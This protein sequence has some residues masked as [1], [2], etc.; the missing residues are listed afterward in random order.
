MTALNKITG[1]P[2]QTL[3][4][5]LDASDFPS[6][7][8]FALDKF[9]R[10]RA[11][12]RDSGQDYDTADQMAMHPDYGPDLNRLARGVKRLSHAGVARIACKHSGVCKVYMRQRGDVFRSL[13]GLFYWDDGKGETRR[14]VLL[15]AWRKGAQP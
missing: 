12:L 7:L 3:R 2:F 9:D 14:R 5:P 8:G 1:K 11:G 10:I 13:N 6:R 4:G 15:L